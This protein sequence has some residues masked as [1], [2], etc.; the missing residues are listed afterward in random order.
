[1]DGGYYCSQRYYKDD[2]VKCIPSGLFFLSKIQASIKEGIKKPGQLDDV[3]PVKMPIKG[4]QKREVHRKYILKR[5]RTCEHFLS[6]MPVELCGRA[7]QS[8]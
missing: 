4:I 6:S 7:S 1:M 5:K 2:D 3:I 8:R